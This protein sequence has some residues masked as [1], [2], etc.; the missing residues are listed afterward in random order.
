MLRPYLQRTVTAGV[1][2]VLV[3]SLLLVGTAPASAQS[4]SNGQ[5]I[6]QQIAA[7]ERR[8]S[9]LSAQVSGLSLPNSATP[10]QLT[11]LNQ[12]VAALGQQLGALSLSNST[13]GDQLA[14][15]KQQMAALE[16]AASGTSGAKG[17]RVVDANGVEIGPMISTSEVIRKFGESWL[18]LGVWPDGF[19]EDSPIF[20]NDRA[21]CQGTVYTSVFPGLLQRASVVRGVVHYASRAPQLVMLAAYHRLFAGGG[22][23]CETFAAPFE[24]SVSEV[25]T[26]DL[27][28]FATPFAVR[29]DQ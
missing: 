25:A 10:E 27:S 18:V 17:L 15:L 19:S 26:A 12:Q 24:Q 14:A 1:F 23:A 9:T 8:L 4:Q 28:A 7:L 13:I 11:A 29:Y 21:D 16:S 3:A 22:S 5:G 20:F 2:S 6:P